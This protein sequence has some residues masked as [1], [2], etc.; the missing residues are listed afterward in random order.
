M[1]K[2][3]IDIHEDAIAIVGMACRLPGASSPN[4]YWANLEAVRESIR[5]F[6][7]DELKEAGVSEATMSNP[8]FVNANGALEGVDMFDARFFGMSPRDAAIMDPQHRI[9]LECAWEALESAGYDPNQYDGAIGVYAG[10][11]MTSYMM[12]HLVSNPEL[13]KTV[14]EFLLRHT[15]NDKDFL[16]TRV[17]Y[18]LN[19]KGPSVNVQ[20][21]CSTSLVAIHLAS[22]ALLSGECDMALAGGVTVMHD[23]DKG[24]TYKEG[25]ILSPDGHCRTFDAASA[26]TVFGSGA[27][28][29]TL[30]RIG[31]A[32]EDGDHIHSVIIGSAVNNDG[33]LKV[34][35]L[36]PSVDGQVEVITEALDVADAHPETI[37]LLEAHGTGTPIGDPIEVTALT[38]AYR[39]KT[40]AKGFCT[41]SSVKTN[42]G[43]LDTAAGVASVMKA[44]LALENKKLPG[45]VHFSSP[46]PKLGLADTPFVVRPETIDWT[47]EGI[48]RRAGV[49]SLGVGGTNAHLILQEA[50]DLG[51][52]VH[53][54][55][56]E[57]LFVLSAKTSAA[58]AD[59]RD[60]LKTHLLENPHVS[61]DDVAYTLQVGRQPMEYRV[62]FTAA[63]VDEAVEK[64]ESLPIPDTVT[65]ATRDVVYMFS[66]Q[67]SQYV[68]MAF[69]L[70]R[71]EA[72][73]RQAVDQ[74]AEQFLP[75][76]D[77]DL[78]QLLYPEPDLESEAAGKLGETAIT[79]PA[80]FTIH[81]ATAKLLMSWGVMPTAMIGHSI[82]EYA[83]ACLAGVFTLQD[84]VRVVAARGRLMQ[85]MQPGKMLTAAITEDEAA[86]FV[87]D[88]LSIAA[89]NAPGMLVLSGPE[90]Q[91][92]VVQSALEAEDI[93]SRILHT[94]HAF[95]S[96][97]MEPAVSQF[98]TT[99]Q[100]ISLG[101]PKIPFVSNTTGE[102]IR[103]DQATSASYWAD[104]IRN[105]VRFEDGIK[106]LSGKGPTVFIEVGVGTTLQTFARATTA[107]M[108]EHSIVGV[109]RHPKEALADTEC[110]ISALGKI[111]AAGA[112]PDWSRFYADES[113]RRV[114]LP[115][116]PFQR[117]SHWIDRPE[118]TNF[119]EQ[120]NTD[121]LT[122]ISDWFSIPSWKR[123]LAKES[124]SIGGLG[125]INLVISRAGD[126]LVRSLT[127]H[128]ID[129]SREANRLV[130]PLRLVQPEEGDID[131]FSITKCER[132]EPGEREIEIRVHAAALQ[133]K[134]VLVALG[135][136]PQGDVP[137]GV[138]CTGIVTRVGKAVT[139]FAVGDAVVATELDSFRT[140]VVRDERVAVRKPAHMS[141]EDAVTIPSAFI[142]AYHSLV[143]RANISTGDKVLIHAATGGVGQAAIQLARLKGADIFATAGSPE[144]R[145]YLESL[146]ITNIYNSRSADFEEE[147]LRDTNGHGVDVVLNSLT[148]D[149]LTASIN[150]LAAN[151]IFLE[152]GKKEVYDNDTMPE[153][154]TQRKVDY[155]PID[156]DEIRVDSPDEFAERFDKLIQLF[157]SGDLSALPVTIFHW[158]NARDA[159]KLMAETR[160]IGKVV[161]SLIPRNEEII[162]VTAGSSFAQVNDN[163]FSID[164]SSVDQYGSLLDAL[165]P[166]ALKIERVIH[167]LNVDAEPANLL[168]DS[169]SDK[170]ANSFK[171]LFA[172]AKAFGER[173]IS[174]PVSLT[175]LSTGLQRIAN[176]SVPD[177]AI[178]L[179]TGPV[180]VIPR[181]YPNISCRSIDIDPADRRHTALVV[182][183]LR[184]D[185]TSSGTEKI[186]AFRGRDRWVQTLE[187]VELTQAGHGWV[188]ENGTY[189]ITGGFGG[190]GYSVATHLA[191]SGR[192]VNIALVSRSAPIDETG[193]TPIQRTKLQ[194]LKDRGANVSFFRANVADKTAM[195]EAV[196]KIRNNYGAITGVF[197]AAGLVDD[198]LIALKSADSINAVLGPKVKGTLVLHHL[199]AKE[200]LD[201]LVLFSSLGTFLGLPGQ[202]DYTAASSFLDAYAQN[203]SGRT[204]RRVVSI[205]WGAWQQVGMAARLDGSEDITA[206]AATAVELPL[207]DHVFRPTDNTIEY[208]RTFSPEDDWILDEHRSP[209]GQ[210]IM[211]GTGYLELLREALHETGGAHPIQVDEVFFLAPLEVGNSEQVDVRVRLE[212][213]DQEYNFSVS[214]RVEASAEWLDHVIGSA[215]FIDDES[216]QFDLSAVR[217]EFGSA[218]KESDAN[219]KTAQER[220]LQFGPRW[221][222]IKGTGFVDNRALG[223]F[224]LSDEFASD[225]L[226]YLIHPA[227][228]DMATG[229]ALPL[230]QGYPF[231]SE[232]YV[233]VSYKALKVFRPMPKRLWS[234]ITLGGNSGSEVVDFAVTLADENGG[235]I[236]QTEAF[237]MKRISADVLR[238]RRSTTSERK[239]LALDLSK[240]IAPQEGLDALDRVLSVECGPQ[241]AVSSQNISALIT[242]LDE[243]Y[244]GTRDVGSS[245]DV[246]V[247]HGQDYEGPRD[248]MDA[249]LA[250]I[251][252]DLL[253]IKRIGINDNFFELGGH[254]LIAVRMFTKVRKEFGVDLQLSSLFEAPTI[255]SYG[256]LI[257][258]TLGLEP[259]PHGPDADAATQMARSEESMGDGIPASKGK[260]SIVQPSKN[261]QSDLGW[262]PVVPIQKSGSRAPFFCVHGAGGNVLNFWDL[263]KYLGT[264][265]PFYGLQAR[266]VDGSLP[267][268]ETF[269]EMASDYIDAIRSVQPHGPYCLGGY[270]AGGVVAFE[271]ARQLIENGEQVA[272]L[273]YIDTFSPNLP[274]KP[275]KSF[276]EKSSKHLKSLFTEG[277]SYGLKLTKTR[278]QFEKNRLRKLA[279]NMY[280][281]MGKK[282]PLNLREILMIEAY[283]R[284]A[285]KYV[286]KYFPGKI[287][288]FTA[289]DKGLN[290]AHV[291]DHMGWEGLADEV[292]IQKVPG[293]HDNLVLEPNV[294]F[295]V[296]ALR[297]ELERAQSAATK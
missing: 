265:Q 166:R 77:L 91:L 256:D 139:R 140:Y 54:A 4:Q 114:P 226:Q 150:V 172:L 178:A 174:Q 159:F 97:S 44:S 294:R 55:R 190:I 61:I 119:T 151:G 22:Q 285:S 264:S 143:E 169:P 261:V 48:P 134:D 250:N 52:S 10:S 95:H 287:T 259:A 130:D 288:L 222:C 69:D 73:F 154:I 208:S 179:L 149:M 267:P 271:M 210:S 279:M 126:P 241:V 67:G 89:L 284:A 296:E 240:G 292:D 155:I 14:G 37:T 60:N 246:D 290:Y 163:E 38:Q 5:F 96:P 187:S 252:Q 111:W 153:V 132:P 205:N 70:Y 16:T 164:P 110:A 199:L 105:P 223:Y 204:D 71:N 160:H 275:P 53:S 98:L 9:F 200:P 2:H 227:V 281:G 42:I 102:F 113:R 152:L 122:E 184:R 229:F 262:S 247:V 62:S 88:E 263:A 142:T 104:H 280:L 215:S 195:A 233:P 15:G 182:E 19:L 106:T 272:F 219:E 237:T 125:T 260:P 185:L 238:T 165:G 78:R 234:Y 180:S 286:I 80:L 86:R 217:K 21:A 167:C 39:A 108:A 235:V 242:T 27:G 158:S 68:N 156:I 57:K 35:Y 203:Q 133:F 171:S 8:D 83:A 20:T 50:P 28:V 228:L 92:K 194:N 26:G 51:P 7:A 297:I 221:R 56:K 79:Q 121:K 244:S 43:H 103:P 29:V 63:T 161:L 59:V 93:P 147:I 72:M 239:E 148:G 289:R 220:F 274:E 116:Y 196:E 175:V 87:T 188:K 255:A 251:W 273:A 276:S 18:D 64:L 109:V 129:K 216:S 207:L 249:R 192:T 45:T 206:L 74:C 99:L 213:R 40:S 25:E 191:A 198:N 82:G 100:S 277:P 17:S 225:C 145:A 257:R 3:Q 23:Q 270:S 269:E 254:S 36:A 11:G 181:E 112:V 291:P 258:T 266:G 243:Q 65:G 183:Q 176:E 6:S 75:E 283:H 224:E 94:S 118:P 202:I 218:F 214:S 30:K 84:A 253:G 49:S 117:S 101:E 137:L 33:S 41:L 144:K 127:T 128:L 124:D 90:E 85:A 141:F 31:Q 212:R 236:L 13:L 231:E 245:A 268:H 230:I 173:E 46:N 107:S 168:V 146:G 138:E 115:T 282:L 24:Y 136:N 170:F 201:L 278:L 211:P 58:L 32:I 1:S 66:G 193:L 47:T 12:Y 293:T 81:Y 76:L 232:F 157:R 189:L 209:L 120:V 162:T 186:V 177:P 135:L 131:R 34:S 295:L 197:H 123:S 248:E